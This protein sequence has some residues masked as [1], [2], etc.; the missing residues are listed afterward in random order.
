MSLDDIEYWPYAIDEVST[1]QVKDVAV[2][3]LLANLDKAVAGQIIPPP[4]APTQTE[5]KRP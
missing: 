4:P 2:K 3:Y 1:A 5:E